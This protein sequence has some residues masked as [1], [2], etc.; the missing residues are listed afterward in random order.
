[1][2]VG[3]HMTDLEEARLRG[4]VRI[5]YTER[6]YVHPDHHW[7]MYTND[8]FSPQGHLLERRHRNPEGSQW[9]IIC[10]YDDNGRILEKEQVNTEPESR[11]LFSYLYDPLGRLDRVILHSAHEDERVFESVQYAADGTKTRTL[12]PAPLDD[13]KRKTASVGSE[14]MLHLSIDA[15]VIMTALDASDRPIRQVLYDRDDRVIRRVAFRYDARGLL[16]EEGELTG[17]SIRDDF[18]NVYR[19]DA[20]ERQIEADRRWGDIGGAR[21]TFAYNDHGDIVQEVIEQSTGL[22]GE[23]FRPQAWTERFTYQYDDYENWIE[24]TTETILHTGEARL[25]MIERRELTY[26]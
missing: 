18:R 4:R 8:T 26:H 24:R 13:T 10:R 19:Y 20:L 21:R 1:M 9:S 2:N 22:L 12:Y 11:Q 23:D 25:S 3:R 6:D 16:I 14:C 15:V 7:V 17:G 5:C